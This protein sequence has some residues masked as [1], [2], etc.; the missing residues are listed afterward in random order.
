M[1]KISE[2]Q[3][4]MMQSHP[5]LGMGYQF[6]ESERSLSGRTFLL[7]WSIVLI[8]TEELRDGCSVERLVTEP[9]DELINSLPE[10]DEDLSLCEDHE[11]FSSIAAIPVGISHGLGVSAA[12]HGSPPFPAVT[13]SPTTFVRYSAFARDPRVSPTGVTAPGTYFTSIAD[14]H[15]VPSG[16]AAVGRYALPVPR[17]AIYRRDLIVPSSTP[18][19]FGSVTPAFGR[20]GG[21]VEIE[22]HQGAQAQSWTMRTITPM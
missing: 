15:E 19:L 13:P 18:F 2:Q 16:L 21:G 7:L 22:L 1:Y 10:F 3:S 14:S 12:L 4:R 11:R 17:P 5:E 6:L 20:S 9:E 8:S